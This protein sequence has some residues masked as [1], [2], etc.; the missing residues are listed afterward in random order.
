M[1]TLKEKYKLF[2]EFFESTEG[3]GI[4]DIDLLEDMKLVRLD[5]NGD[6]IPET[7]SPL[8]GAAFNAI[9]GSNLQEP[10]VSDN[11]IADYKSL[12]QKATFFKQTKID[13]ESD[14]LIFYNE[15]K[16]KKN[17]L[18]RG[19]KESKWRLSSS[20]QRFWISNKMIEKEV[21]YEDFLSSLVKNCREYYN[22]LIPKY[23][24][25][26]F[27]D[28][29]N[30]LAI[31]SF[32]QH[33]GSECYTPLLDWTYSFQN[34]LF[35]AIEDSYPK[36][37]IF[38]IDN[39]FS[40]YYIEE[41]FL[42]ADNIIDLV[43]KALD[44]KSDYI[45]EGYLKTIKATPQQKIHFNAAMTENAKKLFVYQLEGKKGIRMLTKIPKLMRFPILFCSDKG[46]S[47]F[48]NYSIFNSLKIVNQEGAFIW[49]NSPYK[50]IEYVAKEEYLKDNE[51]PF[52]FCDCLNIN[53]D[54]RYYIEN[55]IKKDN[56]TKD[57]I[58]PNQDDMA[59]K[60]F[61]KTII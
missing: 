11:F 57:Y 29:D 61:K 4:N 53:K 2:N 39:Y 56:I 23:F 19:V 18:F 21:K 16:S 10:F 33:H 44:E 46:T 14:F 50:P 30:D 25:L 8:L 24:K 45:I 54:L 60:I 28:S 1:L 55:L 43:K 12:L 20:L 13:T 59:N 9:A 40:I 3:R 36:K 26:N 37:S 34:S 41:E 52:N 47:S 58:Y 6:P 49:S 35:F 22:G 27:K 42:N 38:E 31:L 15:L 51:P 7:V 5:K 48:I 32:L 17:F